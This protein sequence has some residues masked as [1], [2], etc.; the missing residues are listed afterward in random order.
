MIDNIKRYLMLMKYSGR[1][2]AGKRFWIII[3]LPLIWPVLRALFIGIGWSETK[4]NPADAHMLISLPL[5]IVAMGLGLRIIAGEIDSRTLEIAYTVPGGCHRVWLA[6]IATCFCLLFASELLL[7][8][9]TMVF[10]VS[11]SIGAFYGA[12]QAAMFYL[13]MGMGLS[14]FFRSEITGAMATI[15]FF[16]LGLMAS[17]VRISPFFNPLALSPSEKAQ[18][19]TYAIQNRIFFIIFIVAITLLTFLRVERREKM[20]RD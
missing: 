19:V 4:F 8:L 6:K 16:A 10:L 12:L 18:A 11:V 13:V 14:A 1:L 15:V 7:V 2:M 20:L 9:F 17:S 3:F 5:S